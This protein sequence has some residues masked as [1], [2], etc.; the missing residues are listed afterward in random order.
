MPAL[1]Y[2]HPHIV[3]AL[4]KDG[5]VVDDREVRVRTGERTVYIDLFAS[6]QANGS[7]QQIL[8]GVFLI[9]TAQ[10]AT[11]TS[12]LD[13]ISFIVLFSMKSET[14]LRSIWLY[15]KRYMKQYLIL[16]FDVQSA[17]IGLKCLS[18]I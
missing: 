1:D 12:Q 5:W 10:H 16:R 13:S 11:Y 9:V 8:L 4:E 14:P 17:I 6:R 7:H 2:C 18:S 3:R 15:R